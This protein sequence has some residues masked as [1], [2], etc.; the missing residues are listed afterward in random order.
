MLQFTP[1]LGPVEGGT[2]VNF[3]DTTRTFEPHTIPITSWVAFR[4]HCQPAP[5][6]RHRLPTCEHSPCL[7]ISDGDF[8]VRFS[9]LGWVSVPLAH[10][11]IHLRQSRPV[12]HRRQR[13]CPD[14]CLSVAL[15]SVLCSWSHSCSCSCTSM[16]CNHAF[17]ILM[18][19]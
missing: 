10:L 8:G 17:Y 5:V 3:V 4:L 9:P 13:Y 6:W 16:M 15:R 1:F 11:A 2:C 12:L 7:V 18:R 14:V 19:T